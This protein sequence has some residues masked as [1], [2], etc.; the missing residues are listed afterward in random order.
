[1]YVNPELWAAAK[2]L[3]RREGRTLS[4]LVAWLLERELGWLD[5]ES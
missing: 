2:V 5:D 4:G 3:A 1:M